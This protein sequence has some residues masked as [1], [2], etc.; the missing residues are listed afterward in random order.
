MVRSSIGQFKEELSYDQV[1]EEFIKGGINLMQVRFLGDNFSLLTPKEG[2]DFE[3]F[4]SDNQQWVDSVFV[5]IKPWT[6]A[7]VVDH[8]RVWVRCY[9]LPLALW[10]M[11]GFTKVVGKEVTLVSVDGATLSWENVEFARLQVRTSLSHSLRWAKSMR[12]NDMWCSIVMEEEFVTDGRCVCKCNSYDSTVNESSSET[13]VE[14]SSLSIK[15]SED[16]LRQWEGECIRS[17]KEE[18]EREAKTRG[19]LGTS[20]KEQFFKE[21]SAENRD[22]QGKSCSFFMKEVRERRTQTEGAEV[23]L[24]S[25]IACAETY[26]SSPVHADLAKVVVDIEVSSLVTLKVNG[27]GQVGNLEAQTG[28]G[29]DQSLSTFEGGPRPAR[30][31]CGRKEESEGYACGMQGAIEEAH[32]RIN[33]RNSQFEE[34]WEGVT[35]SMKGVQLD[36]NGEY[37]ST[38]KDEYQ[39]YGEGI[40]VEGGNHSR[41]YSERITGLWSPPLRQRKE[42]GLTD[43][44]DSSLPQRRRSVRLHEKQARSAPSKHQQEGKIS[45]SISDGYIYN[46]NSRLCEQGNGAEPAVLWEIGKTSGI[47]CHGIEEEV[48]QEYVCME[49]RNGG[50]ETGQGGG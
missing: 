31:C 5:S 29:R 47:F 20:S 27:L 44:G 50:C 3:T 10:N 28:T 14:E 11:D 22:D 32:A 48:V 18:D 35:R 1:E 6:P 38:E 17:W 25:A 40:V 26:N 19:I 9:G 8:K 39:R 42:K 34:N 2:A 4:Y 46:C 7:F 45:A 30:E 13:Y 37:G 15:S 23:G 33:D 43:L 41:D 36:K 16:E 49:E 24:L 21:S 12:L